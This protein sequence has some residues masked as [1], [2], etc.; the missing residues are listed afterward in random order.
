MD[1]DRLGDMERYGG[2]EEVKCFCQESQPLGMIHI[3]IAKGYNVMNP[4]GL[5]A[6]SGAEFSNVER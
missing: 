2:L 1:W 3:N 5:K 6:E 4:G